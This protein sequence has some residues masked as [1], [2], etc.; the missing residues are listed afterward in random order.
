LGLL[1]SKCSSEERTPIFYLFKKRIIAMKNVFELKQTRADLI[2]QTEKILDAADEGDRALTDE[3][4][5]QYDVAIERIESLNTD[6]E[7]KMKLEEV[8]KVNFETKPLASNR[9]PVEAPSTEE[10]PKATVVGTQSGTKIE[11]IRSYSKL[12]AFPKSAKGNE[13]AYRAG[14]WLRATLYGDINASEW[15]RQNGV[16]VRAALSGGVNTAGGALVPEELERAIIDLRETYGV[17]RQNTRVTPMSSDTKK[18]PRRVGGLTAYFTGENTAG[19]ESDASWDVVSLV[20]KKLMVLTRMSSEVADDAIIDLADVMAQEIAYA[21]ALKE[22]TVGFNGDGSASD[23]G[24]EGVLVKAI[25]GSHDL[26][27]VAAAT[28]HNLLGEIDADDLL[29][30]M[31]AIPQFAKPGAKW[32]CSPTAQELVFNAIKIAGGGNTRDMLADSD[33]PRFLGY[34]IIVTPV[35]A[36]NPATD[37]DDLVMIGFGNLSQ[38]ATMGER[39]GIRIALSGDKYWEEDQIGIKGTERFDIN[40]HDLG[41]STIKS[42]FAV[43]IG[44]AA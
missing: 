9:Q 42:P 2:V 1:S 17:F 16:G 19:T 24:I 37:Y 11:S 5:S 12:V 29:K 34:P 43:L 8:C 35:M 4:K 33:V 36:D 25:N 27:K 14:Q 31:S 28:P 39:R 41:S 21:F 30:L 23:G 6:I 40:V 44:D 3:E 32:Y 7:R 18:I 20:A 26:A 38:A 22:D 10:I 13:S 15:C